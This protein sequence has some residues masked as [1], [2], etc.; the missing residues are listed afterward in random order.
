MQYPEDND[1]DMSQFIKTWAEIKEKDHKF[2]NAFKHLTQARN[3]QV[4]HFCIL[5]GFKVSPMTSGIC[6]GDAGPFASGTDKYEDILY[7]VNNYYSNYPQYQPFLRWIT[8]PQDSPWKT[9]LHKSQVI[10]DNNNCIASIMHK[11][12]VNAFVMINMGIGARLITEHLR[13]PTWET[14]VKNGIHPAMAYIF[15][16][17]FD[18]K[19]GTMRVNGGH[20]CFHSHRDTNLHSFLTGT[21]NITKKTEGSY[22]DGKGTSRGNLIWNKGTQKEN[23]EIWEKAGLKTIMKKNSYGDSYPTNSFENPDWAAI[24]NNIF[25]QLKLEPYDPKSSSYIF[26]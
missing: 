5:K 23:L 2:N 25:Q 15:T 18:I 9:A 4:N 20:T 8:N 12:D 24:Q 21:P 11:A 7:W 3:Y 6:H 13:Y 14:H 1:T 26:G 17:Y 19:E 10:I 22:Q 16:Y